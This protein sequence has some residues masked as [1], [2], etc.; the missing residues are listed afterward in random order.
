MTKIIFYKI[1]VPG[2]PHASLRSLKALHPYRGS[3]MS[4]Y[5]LWKRFGLIRNLVENSKGGLFW[6]YVFG[7]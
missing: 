6:G 3:F 4:S 1:E 5:I 2:R 7:E